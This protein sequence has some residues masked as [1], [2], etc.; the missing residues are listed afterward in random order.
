[1]TYNQIIDPSLG[2]CNTRGQSHCGKVFSSFVSTRK[3]CFF[4]WGLRCWS[5][6]LNKYCPTERFVGPRRTD[7]ASE[8]EADE[9][10]RWTRVYPETG[11]L[12]SPSTTTLFGEQ[13][14]ETDTCV[15]AMALSHKYG[16]APAAPN[17]SR[18]N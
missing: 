18:R 2:C 11:V 10:E 12:E 13:S 15:T 16:C 9:E 6:P 17:A 4:P 7:M 8:R 5:T 14:N 3:G 1:M